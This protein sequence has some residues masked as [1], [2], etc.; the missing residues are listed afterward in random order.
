MRKICWLASAASFSA[1]IYQANEIAN[2]R[3]KM[4]IEQEKLEYY[5]NL[6]KLQNMFIKEKQLL[7]CF[8]MYQLRYRQS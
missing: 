4:E 5:R 3:T 7:G 8:S 2:N 6:S 1:H